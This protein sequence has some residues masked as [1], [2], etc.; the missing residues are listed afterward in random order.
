MREPFNGHWRFD[1]L[2][3]VPVGGGS[4]ISVRACDINAVRRRHLYDE[5]NFILGFVWPRILSADVHAHHLHMDC[6]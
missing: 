1:R 2:C 3:Y 6:I 5:A 4:T